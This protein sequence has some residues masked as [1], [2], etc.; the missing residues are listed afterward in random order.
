MGRGSRREAGPR[1]RAVAR[2]GGVA[3]GVG[4]EPLRPVARP[5]VVA[6]PRRLDRLPL[7]QGPG[8]VV[9][10]D[11]H[12]QRAALADQHA[13]LLR[14]RDHR[15]EEWA[16]EQARVAAVADEDHHRHLTALGLVHGDRV[17]EAQVAGRRQSAPCAPPARRPPMNCV[18]PLTR[19]SISSKPRA[20]S[21]CAVT[22]GARPA[23]RRASA[24]YRPAW[25][26]SPRRRPRCIFRGRPSWPWR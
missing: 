10:A 13:G 16:G 5:P 25:R 9:A 2:E 22:D 14:A 4:E 21:A 8:R 3:V 20:A 1:H 19:C 6:D 26:G 12:L 11:G 15:V 7:D 23:G 17:G 18:M 24:R